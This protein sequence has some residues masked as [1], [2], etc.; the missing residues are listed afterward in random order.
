MTSCGGRRIARTPQALA[1][2]TNDV[3][4]GPQVEHPIACKHEETISRREFVDLMKR[5]GAQPRIQIW[6][7]NGAMHR[8]IW[9]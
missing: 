3:L 8:N 7:G 1:D 5:D 9:H 2:K 6:G 4:V